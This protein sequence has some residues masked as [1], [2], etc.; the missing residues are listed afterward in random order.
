MSEMDNLMYLINEQNKLLERI[1]N[2]LERAYP[3]VIITAK[4]EITEV[5][6]RS[7]LDRIESTSGVYNPAT[8]KWE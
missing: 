2:A 8:Y 5:V 7:V 3:P 1:A 6:R 4:E